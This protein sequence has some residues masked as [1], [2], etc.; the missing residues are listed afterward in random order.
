MPGFQWYPKIQH[1]GDAFDET[2]P[3]LF[4]KGNKSQRFEIVLLANLNKLL[5]CFVRFTKVFDELSHDSEK[6]SE[7]RTS[8][9]FACLIL[10]GPTTL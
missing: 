2:T 8:A 3:S 7:K 4:L 1:A 10:V 5:A 6:L 9:L